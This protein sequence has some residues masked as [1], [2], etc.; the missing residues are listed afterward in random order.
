M[1]AETFP[2][3]A[4]SELSNFQLLLLDEHLDFA[5]LGFV[6]TF[7]SLLSLYF[8]WV[9]YCSYNLSLS[10]SSWVLLLVLS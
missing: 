1:T 10:F 4:I 2:C 3:M 8:L 7:L 5:D 9:F 6:C